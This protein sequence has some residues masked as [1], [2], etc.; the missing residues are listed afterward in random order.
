MPARP[1]RC[2]YQLI[3]AWGSPT[4]LPSQQTRAL[5]GQLLLRLLS[6]DVQQRGP[7]G[8]LLAQ[9]GVAVRTGPADKPG[10]FRGVRLLPG[11]ALEA[12]LPQLRQ[13]LADAVLADPPHAMR[14]MRGHPH[15]VRHRW[16]VDSKQPA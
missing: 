5:A 2:S 16:W 12:A 4:E 13:L 15:R 1:A 11:E 10:G 3:Y 9:P 7:I 6:R 8:A 14:W